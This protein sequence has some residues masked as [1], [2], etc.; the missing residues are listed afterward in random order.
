MSREL[1]SRARRPGARPKSQGSKAKML[2]DKLQGK[3]R[4]ERRSK[5]EGPADIR[6]GER[7]RNSYDG[8]SIP[9]KEPNGHEW[10]REKTS[11]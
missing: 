8:A 4:E 9:P 2:S 11:H 10:R 6:G 7:H 5:K 1:V 3:E